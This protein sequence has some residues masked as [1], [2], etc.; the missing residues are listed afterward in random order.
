MVE[1]LTDFIISASTSPLSYL[2]IGLLTIIDAVFPAVPSESLVISMASVLAP[3]RP[4]LL[5]V[6]FVVAAVCAWIGDNLAFFIGR[7]PAVR[8]SRLLQRASIHRGLEWSRTKLFERGTVVIVVGRFIPGARIAI[9][10]ACGIVGYSRRRFMMVVTASS[11]LWAGFSVG[12][13]SLA[14]A[15]FEAHPLVGILLAVTLGMVLGPLIDWVLRRTVLRS[16]G[17]TRPHLREESV[18][19]PTPAPGADPDRT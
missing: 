2:V 4:G 8:N 3:T 15:W 6:L 19:G 7:A 10:V 12:V 14:G 16:P 5:A 17:E 18:G 1:Q 9:N 11:M 13:G